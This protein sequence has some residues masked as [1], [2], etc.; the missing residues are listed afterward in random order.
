AHAHPHVHESGLEDVH[1]H[2]H[3]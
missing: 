1:E 3:A 2:E